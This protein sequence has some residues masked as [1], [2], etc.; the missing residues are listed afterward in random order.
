MS[1]PVAAAAP[2]HVRA[3]ARYQG[4]KPISE[5][6]REHGLHEADIV[7]LASNENPLGVPESARAAMAREIAEL[8]RYP[9]GNGYALKAAIARRVALPADWITLGNGSGDLLDLAVR[10]FVRPGDSV[11]YS[12]HAFAVYPIATLAGGARAIVVPA[13]ELAHDLD[14]MAAAVAPDTRL[15]FV[16]NPNNPTGTFAPAPKIA[17]FLAK[18]PRDVAVVLDEAYRE[19]L[20]PSLRFDATQWLRAHPNLIVTR[21]FSKAYG[22][23]G[24]RI[25]FALADPELTDLLNRVRQPFNVNSLAQA[26]AVAALD[27]EAFV[28][29]SYEVNREGLAYLQSEL[30]RLRLTFVPSHA[31]FVLVQLGDAAAIYQRLLRAGVIVRPV[32]NYGLPQWLRVSIGL[33]NENRR[34][35]AALERALAGA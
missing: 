16:G 35:V 34:F 25:G 14:A 28:Q 3:I 26:A 23:A 11:V 6:A 1:N 18:V 17:E 10:A 13:R 22:L 19:Y 27:D 24:L 5:L 9:D 29:R 21:T 15:V 7:K 33:P 2:A 32:A 30:E 20:E 31:N 12:Q 8:A 4:G